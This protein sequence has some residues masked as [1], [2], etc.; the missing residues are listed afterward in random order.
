MS[1]APDPNAL[2]RD[3]PSD[4]AW[5]QLVPRAADAPVP[6]WPLTEAS[7][8]E[9]EL[10]AREWQRP[11]ADQWIANDEAQGVALFVR[12]LAQGEKP[13]APVTIHKYLRE[14]R[15]ELGISANG[16]ATRRWKMPA[17]GQAN[18]VTPLRAVEPRRQS[19]RDRVKRTLPTE[20]ATRDKPPF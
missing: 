10:W 17:A 19:S 4:P 6:D 18:S 7:P 20:Q 5:T 11:Q 9:L 1:M 14:W 8:R 13:G 12:L 3:R 2:R 16:A 15:H